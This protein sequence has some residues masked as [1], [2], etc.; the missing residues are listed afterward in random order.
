MRRSVP[1]IPR[2]AFARTATGTRTG[3]LAV[4]FPFRLTLLLFSILVTIAEMPASLRGMHIAKHGDGGYGL[5]QF[6]A[7]KFAVIV[8]DGF[9]PASA[10]AGRPPV[11][12]KATARV[13]IGAD[14]GIAAPAWRIRPTGTQRTRYIM[15][16]VF[17]RRT[18]RTHGCQWESSPRMFSTRHTA[19]RRPPCR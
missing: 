10:T 9:R 5:A 7:T 14:G 19:V 12:R 2:F 15:Y 13:R 4:F 8:H 6:I 11:A 17:D 3:G 16:T 18:R 1:D